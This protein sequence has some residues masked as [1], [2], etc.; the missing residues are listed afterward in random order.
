MSLNKAERR[1][2]HNAIE[3]A[4]RECLNSK[5]QQLAEA[6]PN[7][8][9]HR[10]PSK[11]QI[12]EKALDWVRQNMSKEDRYQYQIMQLQNENKR[13]LTQINITQQQ[14]QQQDHRSS[15]IV[16][17]PMTSTSPANAP[18]PADL[19]HQQ[20]PANST[21]SCASESFNGRERSKRPPNN[22]AYIVQA[23]GLS[24][25]YPM[26]PF[27]LEWHQQS[28]FATGAECAIPSASSSSSSSRPLVDDDNESHSSSEEQNYHHVQMSYN[29]MSCK[30]CIII[31]FS[32]HIILIYYLK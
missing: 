8:Q 17:P 11:G 12:V 27:D 1:A 10:R 6:L 2:E 28:L 16:T 22:A 24:M 29:D 20:F 18:F 7:L 13:L 21:P 31:L 25:M 9:N 15:G 26:A 5:F 14:Q 19:R 3:R 23:K 30:Y 4:R 32:F